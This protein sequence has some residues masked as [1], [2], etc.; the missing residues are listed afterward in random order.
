MCGHPK[1]NPDEPTLNP[2]SSDVLCN[3]PKEISQ[4]EEE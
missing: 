1:L 2:L 4:T 3:A